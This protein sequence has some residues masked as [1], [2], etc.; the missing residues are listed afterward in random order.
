[1]VVHDL[2]APVATEPHVRLVET[3]LG[4]VAVRS[5]IARDHEIRDDGSIPR[6]AD[7]NPHVLRSGVHH[8]TASGHQRRPVL[9]VL[10]ET[11]VASVP[12]LC[13]IVGVERPVGLEIVFLVGPIQPIPESEDLAFDPG[14]L[15]I[16]EPT[17]RPGCR[18]GPTE[19]GCRR[20]G[21]D[22]DSAR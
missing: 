19:C 7:V 15:L 5:A 6:R 9:L 20:A 17:L 3:T 10:L 18:T 22:P 12:Y 21:R 11:H 16:R 1:M 8:S 2:P 4:L 13:Q 14:A